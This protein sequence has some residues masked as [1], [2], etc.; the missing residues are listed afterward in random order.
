VYPATVTS[1]SVKVGG[2][3]PWTASAGPRGPT[4]A[5]VYSGPWLLASGFADVAVRVGAPG[6][7]ALRLLVLVVPYTLLALG[8]CVHTCLDLTTEHLGPLALHWHLRGDL[9]LI[10]LDHWHSTLY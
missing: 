8:T 9:H 5:G 6:P 7:A 10:M 3:L 1:E 2:T 4:R